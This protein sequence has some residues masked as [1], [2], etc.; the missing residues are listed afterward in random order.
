MNHRN[1]RSPR[2]IVPQAALTAEWTC[3]MH[4][5]I[6][7]SAPGTCPICGMALEPRNTAVAGEEDQE[8]RSM[9]RRF[10]FSSALT[11]PLL[12]AV[13]GEMVSPR[14]L[15][16]LSPQARVWIELVLASPVCLWAAWPF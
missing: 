10:W 2:V 16:S 4:P 5:E 6:I 9:T 3:P 14:M 11:A 13:M 8:L 7:R 1:T 12:L 15:S